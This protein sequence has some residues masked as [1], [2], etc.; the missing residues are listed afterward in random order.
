MKRTRYALLLLAAALLLAAC[1]PRTHT[2]RID[3]AWGRASL[4]GAAA[5]S[6]R[7]GLVVAPDGSYVAL[8]YPVRPPEGAEDFLHLLVLNG[9]GDILIDQD[10]EP[11]FPDIQDVQ[12][13]LAPTGELHLYWLAGVFSERALWHAELPPMEAPSVSVLQPEQVSPAGVAVRW[14]RAELLPD[15]R[16]LVLWSD[17]DACVQ[18]RVG[19]GTTSDC[20]MTG[21]FGVDFQLDPF[22]VAHVVWTRQETA[23]RLTLNHGLLT[24][25][26]WA[27]E[28]RRPVALVIIPGGASPDAIN[29]PVISLGTGYDYVSWTQEISTMF[30]TTQQQRYVAVPQAD[31]QGGVPTIRLLESRQVNVLPTFPPPAES[32]HGYFSYQ[33][34]VPA[35]S[36]SRG[37]TSVSGAPAAVSGRGEESALATSALYY[38]RSREG[39]QPTVMVFRDG[40]FVGYQALTWTDHPS[41]NAAIAADGSNNLYVA[42]N[43]ATGESYHYPIYL[44][45]TAPGLR[46]AW[47]RLTFQDVLSIASDLF[48]RVVSGVFLIPLTL[49]WLLV[50]FVWILAAV[51][52]SHGELYGNQGRVVLIV[53][54]WIYWLSKYLFSQQIL[55][56]LPSLDYL[57]PTVATLA[58]YLVPVFV[59]GL[60]CALA[61]L[62]YYRR[63]SEDDFSAMKAYIITAGIDWVLSL[64]I[65]ATG[66]FE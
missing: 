46:A 37:T 54:L 10:F 55:A 17:A 64:A 33:R 60:S 47:Q 3:P 53:A 23:S 42:W 24:P 28:E 21:V 25:D 65:Y 16:P 4:V 34:L 2:P 32:A 7:I 31:R 30:G 20:L 62:V 15:G 18:G 48:N 22:G 40:G 50:P 63:T 29:G 57:P 36:A 52:V 43:D 12:L 11:S 49:V 39:F 14:H 6:D 61:S 1:A 44:A 59:L 38:T 45:T 13:L 35:G 41:V 8:A 26:S 58:V 5:H 66:Y 19:T 56:T 9:R 51:I 27:F